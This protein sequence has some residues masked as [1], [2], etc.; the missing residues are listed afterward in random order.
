VTAPAGG[1]RFFNEAGLRAYVAA[2]AVQASGPLRY[3]IDGRFWAY[4]EGVW[5]PGEA[6]LHA[7]ICRALGD[8]Y[9]PSHAEAIRHVLRAEAEELPM[10]PV[11][12]MINM[13]NGMIEWNADVAPESYPH[14][15]M[16][17]ST[18]Q[19]PVRWN[20]GARCTAFEAFLVDAINPDDRQRVWEVLGYLM[21]SGNPLQRIFLLIGGGGNGKGVLLHVIANLLGHDN[22]S[23][24]PMEDFSN[25]KFATAEVFGKLANVCGDIDASYVES[26][27]RIKELAGEDRLK[28]ERKY[29]QPFYF[30]FWGKNV[31]SANGIPSSSDSSVGWS[32]RFECIHFPNEPPAPDRSLKRRLVDDDQLEG[33]AYRAIM[34]LRGLMARGEF[35]RGESAYAIHTEFAQR[36]NKVL[37]WI[38]EN[39]YA[40]PSA[41]HP[42][43]DLLKD[44]R[45]WDGAENPGART[46][47]SQTFYEKL[48]QVKGMR[49][50]IR[51]G[52]RGF[53]G[54]RLKKG[55][56]YIEAD[57]ETAPSEAG[58][59]WY[60]DEIDT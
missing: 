30:D 28:G 26:T 12:R 34:A 55:V 1:Q 8:R 16:Y 40:D 20:P 38:E 6:V 41:W 60:Q 13:A 27:G 47:G 29:G 33:I 56:T 10:T 22:I 11:T 2:S 44:F 23:S 49:E 3:G 39:G 35:D 37:A 48:R 31:F 45:W 52:T 5:G 24:V 50:A 43:R 9:R 32:R 4:S 25:D 57:S 21:M 17:G 51:Q 15:E 59:K 14:H 54:L 36:N 53:A 18:V 7:R 42:R 46:M 58:A 19:L